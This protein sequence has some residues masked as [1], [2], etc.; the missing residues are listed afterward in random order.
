MSTADASDTE[1]YAA[2][3]IFVTVMDDSPNTRV[4]EVLL[5]EH[6]NALPAS[7]ICRLSGLDRAA[8]DDCIE[9]LRRWELVVADESAD[10]PVYR[11]NTASDEAQH[12]A[13]LV[14][15][16]L[17]ISPI[18][19]PAERLMTRCGPYRPKN[20]NRCCSVLVRL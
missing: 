14:G 9:I 16:S 2:G 1:P 4:L 13:N 18:A 20:A 3:T 10:E 15:H 5:S 12:L 7:D 11:L 19:K 17:S 8:F 6:G